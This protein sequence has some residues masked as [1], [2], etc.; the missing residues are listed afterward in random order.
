MVGILSANI[1][2]PAPG[3]PSSERWWPPAAQ[4][5]AARR[6]IDWPSMSAR[7]GA[8][9]VLAE[10]N[11]PAKPPETLL[12]AAASCGSRAWPPGRSLPLLNSA[13]GGP[14]LRPGVPRSQSAAAARL[15][16]AITRTPG[17]RAASG[18]FC[19]ATMT[20][21]NP[22]GAAAATA[23]ST[24]GTGRSRPSKP[25]SPKNITPSDAALGTVPAA[26][27]SPIA[28]AKSNQLPRLGRLAGES[29]TVIFRCGHSS[30]LLTI[31]ARIRSRA[32]RSAVSGRPTRIMPTR[33][34]AMSASTSTT[35]P[36][37]PTKATEYVRAS[38][39]ASPLP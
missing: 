28:M 18:A 19:S 8:T 34:F 31:A 27:S 26:V 12:R 39:T 23:G 5:S 38:G 6:A 22:L 1:V 3:G 36:V 17:T 15:P 14:L 20:V 4:I 29:P 30:P 10:T 35:W 32:S 2:L 24:P 9:A 25:S 11:W 37:T 13:A 33:P 21:P 7:S 16:A